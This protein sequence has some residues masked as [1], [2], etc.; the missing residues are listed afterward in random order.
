MI[1]QFNLLKNM[2]KLTDDELTRLVGKQSQDWNV[3]FTKF[4]D[5]N[6]VQGFSWVGLDTWPVVI[7]AK[8][9]KN[10]PIWK[11]D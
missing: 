6:V 7:A 8:K 4:I 5:L 2:F 10:I 3:L 9:D 11:K 1:N